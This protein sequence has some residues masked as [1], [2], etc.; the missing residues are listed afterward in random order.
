MNSFAMSDK[1]VFYCSSAATEDC[2]TE[3]SSVYKESGP[4]HVS[5]FDISGSASEREHRGL[6]HNGKEGTSSYVLGQPN[7]AAQEECGGKRSVA[8]YAKIFIY[9]LV[10]HS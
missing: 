3:V 10:Y 1:C 2:L 8:S 5:S 6:G 7:A 9:R 4:D